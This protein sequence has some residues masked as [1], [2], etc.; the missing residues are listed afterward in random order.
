MIDS[1]VC[2]FSIPILKES[3]WR[4]RSTNR[5]QTPTSELHYIANPRCGHASEPSSKLP[6]EYKIKDTCRIIATATI[7][8]FHGV[9]QTHGDFGDSSHNQGGRPKDKPPF[10]EV[11]CSESPGRAG[12]GVGRSELW[13][14]L[15]GSEK[16][17]PSAEQKSVL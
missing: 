14:L 9:S 7:G 8:A 6:T 10:I 12:K 13:I 3:C 15:G 17:V 11:M 1:D 16:V 2:D 4:H 5:W